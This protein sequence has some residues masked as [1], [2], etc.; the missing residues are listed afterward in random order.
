MM[1]PLLSLVT[2]TMM[3]APP[4]V[5]QWW[6][7]EP[8]HEEP[9]GNGTDQTTTVS[10]GQQS[11]EDEQMQFN[12]TGERIFTVD[13]LTERQLADARDTVANGFTVEF[14]ADLAYW[15]WGVYA[16]SQRD[17]TVEFVLSDGTQTHSHWV[18][19]DTRSSLFEALEPVAIPIPPSM[20]LDTLEVTAIMDASVTCDFEHF[21]HGTGFSRVD[22]HDPH[23][24]FQEPMPSIEGPENPLFP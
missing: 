5:A 11:E 12:F 23:L 2:V 16:A 22:V 13:S 14:V 1:Q 19:K 24:R 21:S 6:V 10:C 8:L 15:D 17:W 20:A 7:E 3:L 9:G 4:W 18:D